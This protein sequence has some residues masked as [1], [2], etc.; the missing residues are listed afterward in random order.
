MGKSHLQK[1]KLI[2]AVNVQVIKGI[3]G[4]RHLVFKTLIIV[5]YLKQFFLD[6]KGKGANNQNT[7]K[8]MCI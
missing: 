8:S 6:D 7:V 2:L 1:Q 5:T 3:I 4:R